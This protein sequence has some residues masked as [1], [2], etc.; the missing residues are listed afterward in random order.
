MPKTFKD[1]GIDNPD[2]D[3]LVN[4]ITNNG[5]K[6]IPHHIKDMDKEVLKAIFKS[7]L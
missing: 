6:T 3:C 5:E 1:L 2:I 7:C 4:L